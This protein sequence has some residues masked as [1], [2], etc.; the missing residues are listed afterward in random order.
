M[1][2]IMLIIKLI[3][4]TINVGSKSKIVSDISYLNYPEEVS[5]CLLNFKRPGKL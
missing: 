1:L 2:N 5:T 3:R 4:L